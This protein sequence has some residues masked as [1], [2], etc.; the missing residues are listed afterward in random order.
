MLRHLKNS[1]PV[2]L[3][4]EGLVKTT[5]EYGDAGFAVTQKGYDTANQKT[6]IDYVKIASGD[7]LDQFT[8]SPSLVLD[9]ANSIKMDGT[10]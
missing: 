9:V 5:T 8:D 4:E 2:E 6:Y 7:G 3:L 1:P 10:G